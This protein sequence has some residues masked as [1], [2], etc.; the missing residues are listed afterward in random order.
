[1]AS[2]GPE[3]LEWEQRERVREGYRVIERARTKHIASQNAEVQAWAAQLLQRVETWRKRKRRQK[4]QA[5]TAVLSEIITHS[6]VTTVKADGDLWQAML[7]GPDDIKDEL[8]YDNHSLRCAKQAMRKDSNFYRVPRPW[9]MKNRKRRTELYKNLG[10][11]EQYLKQEEEISP[12]IEK[13]LDYLKDGLSDQ[14][15]ANIAEKIQELEE[16][17]AAHIDA[18]S[19]NERLVHDFLVVAA[20]QLI[21]DMESNM[22]DMPS[23][24]AQVQSA[25]TDNLSPFLMRSIR[26]FPRLQK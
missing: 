16:Q 24:S 4:N 10:R 8:D 17:F 11:L 22:G 2:S 1:M 20:H 18:K 12:I 3:T 23:P 5:M 6:Q 15:E 14:S 21:V 13:R 7:D 19:N 26:S 25:F 9:N